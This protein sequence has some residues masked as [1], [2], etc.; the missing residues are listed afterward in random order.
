M[1]DK[2]KNAVMNVPE[3]RF[4]EFSGD[5][6]EQKLGDEF[7]IIGGGT[8]ETLKP[9]YWNG[10][11]QWF[12]PTELKKKYVNNSLRTIT[13][14]GLKKS[15]AKILP[16]GTLLFSSRATIGDVSI[17]NSECTTN[18]GFQSF[19][20]NLLNNI[21]Y[22]YYWIIQNKNEFLKRSSGST[23]LEISK[24]NIEKISISIPLL[25][26]QQ[27]IANFL[28]QVDKRIEKLEEKKEKLEQ[29]KKG[30]MQKLF[31]QQIRFKDEDGNDYPAWEEKKLGTIAKFTKGRNISKA[32]I[33]INGEISCIR[34]GELYTEYGEII[35]EVKSKTNIDSKNLVFSEANDVI[36]PASGETQ[37]DIATASCVMSNGIALGGDLN[38][39]KSP[40]NGIFLSYYLNSV[41]KNDI[42][43]LAQGNAVVHLY[44]K[45][46]KTLKINVPIIEEQQKIANFLSVIDKQIEKTVSQIDSSKVF[47]KGLLQKMFV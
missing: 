7:R 36:I 10:N 9:E 5:W 47:K 30:I 4:P 18:Q 27:K 39:I 37:L 16:K 29:Y 33:D 22:L 12:T 15:S 1:N 28:K 3:L 40:L 8:P 32:D 25:D 26:E 21:E 46:L 35:D 23:F 13:D 6:K 31:S 11:I 45:E 43:S 41:K 14:L 2:L 38:I 19:L 24:S 42:A 34:Y 44:G 20:P 17:T